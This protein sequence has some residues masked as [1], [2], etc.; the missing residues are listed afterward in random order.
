[1]VSIR[2]SSIMIEI[3][4]KKVDEESEN[5]ISGKCTTNVKCFH[6][7]NEWSYKILII[8]I[9]YFVMNS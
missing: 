3:V 6:Y 9:F 7:K 4:N 8:D 1:M 5:K 2:Y